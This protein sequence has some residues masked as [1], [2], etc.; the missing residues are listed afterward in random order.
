VSAAL[1][2]PCRAEH[3][4]RSV[5]HERHV[6]GP[7]GRRVEAI[8]RRHFPDEAQHHRKD[9]PCDD[10][11][12]RFGEAVDRAHEAQQDRTFAFRHCDARRGDATGRAATAAGRRCA[13]DGQDV[14]SA[15]RARAAL[16]RFE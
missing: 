14:T 10:A 9:E 12:D 11:A 3:E 7:F 15:G 5:Q 6:V 4:E 8:A 13:Q 1:Q 2:R 16:P